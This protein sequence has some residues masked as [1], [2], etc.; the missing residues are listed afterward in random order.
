MSLSA[1]AYAEACSYD[2]AILAMQR[3]NTMRAEALLRM[4]ARD[5]DLRATR[6]MA[7]LHI[8]PADPVGKRATEPVQIAVQA[9]SISQ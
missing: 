2:E 6:L 5:G 1:L 3:G 8:D 9:K 4:A 7:K